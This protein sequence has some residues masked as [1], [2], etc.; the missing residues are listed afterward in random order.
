MKRRQCLA[1]IALVTSLLLPNVLWGQQ[2]FTIRVEHDETASSNTNRMLNEMA[3][4][5][6]TASGGKLKLE[7]HSGASLSGGKI[8]T[9]IQNVQLGNVDLGWIST[10]PYVATDPRL[11]V[12]S[13]P[14][15][16]KSI[17]DME[18]VRKSGVLN[19]VFEDQEKRNL[20]VVDMWSRPLRQIINIK[21]EIRLPADAAGMRFRVPEL[22]LFI[23]AFKA[24]NATP[25]PLPFSEIATALQLKT[26]DGAERPTDYL[27][28]EKWWELA[29]YISMV[30]YSGDVVMV[31]FNSAFWKKLGPEN[32]KLLADTIR[33]YGDKKFIVDKAAA[34]EAVVIAQK[35]GMVVTNLTPTELQAFRDAMKGVWTAHADEIGQPLINAVQKVIAEK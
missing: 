26:I 29:K 3:A 9:L 21:K 25:V 6:A 31:S 18:R 32:Q 20:H 12:V 13:L 10:G 5:L 23:D 27:V 1:G 35:N 19:A 30:N 16:F 11:G 4:E 22:R 8:T 14:F 15:I 33:K 34:E 2:A 7:I 28:S 24:L 17:D